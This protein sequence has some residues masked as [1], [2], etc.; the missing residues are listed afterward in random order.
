MQ[1][2]PPITIFGTILKKG[3]VSYPRFTPLL[4]ISV[5][6]V[7]TQAGTPLGCLTVAARVAI[8]AVVATVNVAVFVPIDAVVATVGGDVRVPIDAVVAAV[9]VAFV[10]TSAP[11]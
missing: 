6:G 9:G 10:P 8:D 7:C 1:N 2:A 11:V 4:G 5:A 3:H